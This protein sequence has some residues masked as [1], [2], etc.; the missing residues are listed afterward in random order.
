[1]FKFIIMCLVIGEMICKIAN[2]CLFV[3]SMWH[4][5]STIATGKTKE[6][7]DAIYS[8]YEKEDGN[9]S[10]EVK[11]LK[12]AGC[13]DLEFTCDDG[14]CVHITLRCDQ[15]PNCRDRSDEKGCQLVVLNE[16]YNKDIPPFKMTF[17]GKKIIPVEVN[18]SIN[19]F[20]VMSIDDVHNTID[21]KFEIG[22]QWFDHR[23][24]Y[25]DL[26]NSR[27]FLNTLN[28]TD[29]KRIWLPR[30]VYVNTDQFETTRLGW[31]NE[32]STSVM[33]IPSKGN[34][35]RHADLLQDK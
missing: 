8:P 11:D 15:I 13:K 5:M 17:G 19:I 28:E 4:L 3:F 21:L 34:F 29:L 31:I 27:F 24:T 35:Q 7:D 20:N 23:H 12:P 26:K 1:M 2:S 6:A 18:V 30:I 10:S 22:L 16:G 14:H 32:W 9:T 33:I 25:Y